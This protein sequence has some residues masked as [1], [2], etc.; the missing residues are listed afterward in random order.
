MKGT[1]LSMKLE[2]ITIKQN[3]TCTKSADNQREIQINWIKL[4]QKFYVSKDAI[5]EYKNNPQNG[6]I[7]LQIINLIK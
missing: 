2:Y 7:Y 4:H 1:I 6:Q 3:K 5:R